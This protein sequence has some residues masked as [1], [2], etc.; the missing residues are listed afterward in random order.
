MND[1][2]TKLGTFLGHLIAATI[3]IGAWGILILFIL[4]VCWFI[5][6]RILI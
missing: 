1:F 5:I 4:K 2:W 3:V 6:F